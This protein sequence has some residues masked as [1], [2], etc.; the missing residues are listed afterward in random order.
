MSL[1]V[2]PM[3]TREGVMAWSSQLVYCPQRDCT[4]LDPAW[5]GGVFA[6]VTMRPSQ[7]SKLLMSLPSLVFEAHVGISV[8]FQVR[9]GTIVH[10]VCFTVVGT[11][12][13]FTSLIGNLIKI[14]L[15][16]YLPLMSRDFCFCLSLS[17]PVVSTKCL[18]N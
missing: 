17:L 8:N 15:N 2:V 3:G 1:H 5:R 10:S 13:T 18:Q 11:C 4:S 14:A 16:L 9:G 7:V 6:C 12:R